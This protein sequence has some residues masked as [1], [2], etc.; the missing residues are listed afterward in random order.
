MDMNAAGALNAY[1]HQSALALTGSA[2]QALS[3][4]LASSRPQTTDP[5]A[6]AQLAAA[7]AKPSLL[8]SGLDLLA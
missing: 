6:S 7:A 8:T 5:R 3:R 1:A 2:G 4:R